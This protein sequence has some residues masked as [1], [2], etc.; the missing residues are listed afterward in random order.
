MFFFFFPHLNQRRDARE[1][2][3][4]RIYGRKGRRALNLFVLTEVQSRVI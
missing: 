3:T 2:V 1:G 4:N